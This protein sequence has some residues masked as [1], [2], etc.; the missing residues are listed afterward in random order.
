MEFNLIE[1]RFGF[2]YKLGL[3]K[4]RQE[5]PCCWSRNLNYKGMAAGGRKIQRQQFATGLKAS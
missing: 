1:A 5:Q 2:G 3:I 4:F